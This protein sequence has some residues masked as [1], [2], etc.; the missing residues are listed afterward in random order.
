MKK[1]TIFD[2][3]QLVITMLVPIVIFI[4]QIMWDISWYMGVEGWIY[5]HEIFVLSHRQTS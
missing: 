2:A 4:M 1:Y 5:E 3:L